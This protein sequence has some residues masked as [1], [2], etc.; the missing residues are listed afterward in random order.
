[1]RIISIFGKNLFAIQH[2][3]E[4][5]D[6]FAKMFELWQDPEY[7]EAFFDEHK[8]DLSNSFRGFVSVEDAIIE[9]FEYM[10]E[11]EKELIKLSEQSEANQLEGLDKIFKPLSDTQTSIYPFEKSKAK[12]NWLRLYA[13]KVD[14]NIYV[15]TGGA[16]KLT[17]TMQEREHTAEELKKIE[18]A[19]RFLIEEGIVDAD[20]L[21]EIIENQ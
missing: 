13:L 18:K 2:T 1:M 6:E 19:R 14:N 17:K 11:F 4:T 7:L 5:Q 9:T 15:I 10:Q 8:S 16:I 3:G 12:A 20:G 21:I